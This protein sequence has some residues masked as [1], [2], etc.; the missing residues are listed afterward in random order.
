[1]K[2]RFGGLAAVLATACALIVA[3]TIAA[4]PAAP[5]A[6]AVTV[7]VTG[8]FTN[9]AGL[10]TFTGVLSI[11][12]IASQNGQLVAIGTVTGTL[13]DAL[14]N[15]LGTV[16]QAVTVPLAATG[17]CTILD[18]TLGPLHLNLLGL[19]VDLNQVHL[20][21]T[22]QSGPGQ[23]L[24]NLLCAVSHLLDGNAA[25]TAIANLLNQILALLG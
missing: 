8:S 5:T 7:P 21:I 19:V 4:A 2:L 13:T 17:T 15:V 14:G 1:M 22:A 6:S 10:G 3:P 25:D 24:G 20:Q 18:L 23:L 9:A 12:R 11:D 16:T